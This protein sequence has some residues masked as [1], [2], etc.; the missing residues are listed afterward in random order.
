MSFCDHGGVLALR[1]LSVEPPTPG[2]TGDSLPSPAS[3]GDQRASLC[4][5]ATEVGPSGSS[6]MPRFL[7]LV[8]A[9][10]AIVPARPADQHAQRRAGALAIKHTKILRKSH[11]DYYLL[12]LT[13]SDPRLRTG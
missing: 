3:V 7:L 11:P 8:Q 13:D 2:G 5:V 10:V 6:V 9:M 12:L 4:V 1:P